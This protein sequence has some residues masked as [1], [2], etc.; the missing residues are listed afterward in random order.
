MIYFLANVCAWGASSLVSMSLE[1]SSLSDSEPDELDESSTSSFV[2]DAAFRV[3]FCLLSGSGE[4]ERLELLSLEEEDE[5]AMATISVLAQL[6]VVELGLPREF[7][8]TKTSLT[9][10]DLML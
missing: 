1:L 10:Y 8:C 5:A 7:G 2:F 3:C 6:S 9:I 4:E